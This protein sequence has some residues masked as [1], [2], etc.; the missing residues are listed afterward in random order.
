MK[1]KS[2]WFILLAVGWVCGGA[3]AQALPS[4]WLDVP[5][6]RYTD[7]YQGGSTC[8]DGVFT[9][10]GSGYDV[11]DVANDGGRFAFL[12]LLGDCEVIARVKKLQAELAYGA[13]AGLMLRQNNDRNAVNAVFGRM[14][15]DEVTNIGRI[16]S[17]YRS[18]VNAS[19]SSK[20]GNG[21]DYPWLLMRLIRQGNTVRSYIATNETGTVWELYNTQTVALGDAVNAGIFVSRNNVTTNAL[22]VMT[23]DF[24]QVAV[25]QLVTVQTNAA[26][27]FDVSWVTESPSL[28]NGWSYT[29]LLTRT[30]EGGSAVTQAQDLA[31][32]A[33]ADASVSAGTFYRYA[34]TAVPVPQDPLT[35]PP[36]VLIGTSA[37]T[38][39]PYAVTNLLAGLAQ[40]LYAAYYMPSTAVAPG[41]TRVENSV[42]NVVSLYPAGYTN[43]FKT[44]FNANLQAEAADLYT[45]FIESDDGV[46][47]WVGDT[48]IMDTWYG[49]LLKSSSGPVWL[50]AGRSYP[51]RVEY[52]QSTGARAC[53][54]QWRRAGAPEVSAA[55]PPS[56]LSPVPLPWRHEDIGDVSQN[57]NAAFDLGTGAI[58]VAANGN[59][60]TNSA[61][62][63][64]L[65]S[66]DIENDFDVAVRLD[67]LTGAGAD[68]RAGIV[69]RGDLTP[70]A[71]GVA[72][73]AVPGAGEYTVSVVARD[74]ADAAPSVAAYATG[75]A[76]GSALWLRLVRTGMRVA[77]YY[78][79]DGVTSWSPTRELTNAL[80]FATDKLGLVA[81]SAEAGGAAG[82]VFGAVA[83]TPAP[84]VALL[85]TDDVYLQADD[86]NYGTS[87]NL[88]MRRASG[89]QQREVFLR[90]NVAGLAAVSSAK[91]RLYVQA[92]AA[93]PAVQETVVRR[94]DNL[95]WSETA[96]R[97]S[98]APGGLRVPTVFL[99][100][101]DPTII[102]RANTPQ[103]GQFLEFDL[104]GVVRDAA[105][106]TG[107]LTLNLFTT[108]VYS[109]P[110]NFASKE[111]ADSAKRA[112]IVYALDKPAGL[113][114]DG[115]PETGNISLAWQAVTGATAYRV[116]RAAAAEGPYAQ[117]GGDLT[118]TV[119]KNTGLTGG[120]RYYYT[121]S[122]VL[123][124]GE[125]APSAP[126][127]AVAPATHT[128]VGDNAD[129]Y[130]QGPSTNAAN[131]GAASS[132]NTKY[133]VPIGTTS[134][135][136]YMR[137]DNV[138]GLGH[139]E[140]AVL[141][142][143][144]SQTG[145]DYAA[146]YV[147][148]R[149]MASNSWEEM[150]VSFSNPPPGIVLMTKA[151][152]V[153]NPLTTVRMQMPPAVGNML[154]MD[155]TPLVRRAAALN[156][157]GKMSIQIIRVDTA[158]GN[159][160][161]FYT[162]EDGTA[163]RRPQLVYTLGR[164]A[165]PAVAVSN[166]YASV[167]W[168][169]YRGAVGYVV[170]RAWAAEG[171]YTVV[172]NT[173]ALAFKDL[174]AGVGGIS[175]YT[176]TAVLAGGDAETSRPT[177][178]C[179]QALEARYPV[180]DTMIESNGGVTTT[181]IHGSDTAFNLKLSPV[182]ED[183]FKFD[184]GGL[185][186]A[187][188][189][190]FRVCSSAQNTS[191]TPVN[192][193]VR[194]GDFG[195]WNEYGVTYDAPPRGYTPPSVS[196]SAKGT[197]ELAR[198]NCPYKDPSDAFDNYLEADVTAAVRA[199]AQAGKRYITLFLTGDSTKQNAAGYM[200][201][202]SREYGTL[203]KR[204]V[205]L[206]SAS[207]FGAPQTLR[208]EPL[209][210]QAGFALTWRPVA[211]AV[212]YIVMR[213]GPQDGGSVVMLA[214]S[215]TGTSYT[216]AGPD[217]WN[218]RS[219]T[220]TVT[221][222]NADGTV[223]AAAQVA[224]A[225]P[226]TF[227]RPVVADTFV[228]GGA[229]TNSS[230]AL[231][232]LVEL[233]GDS[234]PD[235]EREGLFRVAVTGL[236]EVV[237]AQLRL[238]LNSTNTFTD[239]TVV[240]LATNDTGWAESGPTAPTWNTVMGPGAGRPPEPAPDDPAVIARFNLKAA[241][242]GRGDDMFFDITAQLKGAQARAEDTLMV[243]MFLTT[244]NAAGNFTVCSLQSADVGDVPYVLYTVARN[245]APG[246][247]LLLK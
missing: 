77:C 38:R 109:T 86:A 105:A 125:A 132:M 136:A 204:P 174:D 181:T 96:V 22:P 180:A 164:T 74:A 193:I 152:T 208:A 95:D 88:T 205:L 39:L 187:T 21:F 245:P 35:P 162:K 213:S 242:Y 179:V 1:R 61:D 170:R 238:K 49:A 66:R 189:V 128:A 138:A 120:Q 94:F 29:Y 190:R 92:R 201:V 16:T 47:M 51:V 215:V 37:A 195:D 186:S 101:D 113:T 111:Y 203:L 25:R 7:A 122:A 32:A 231:S 44:V 106:G 60:M 202:P 172:T 144:A 85:P 153:P 142:L 55:V 93:S 30:P 72:L 196:T 42:S 218:G 126:D 207:R 62:A 43:N 139:V 220:Y 116:Y 159:N 71:A 110:V 18:A 2:A 67:A 5:F 50:E 33:Y 98:S 34:V 75:V 178:V 129:T 59:A 169:A 176:L 102:G 52:Y 148:F 45:F 163:S 68:R 236:P 135:E 183:F 4:G 241:G 79:A 69:L 243:Q 89:T 246:T 99:A 145:P 54:L 11:Y 210:D 46:R 225:L 194:S 12:P 154:E 20:S 82:A 240:L 167:S 84:S 222:V 81:S 103:A 247:Q 146:T 119:L 157:D 200:S 26:A 65:V 232:P 100:D 73:L 107:D 192:F 221:A 36:N 53:T 17:A 177:A 233:K 230:Y 23:N 227:T 123:P 130:V 224:Q 165:A 124:G 149:L 10:A 166:G 6:G 117:V 78:R 70:G 90:F 211:G 115:G 185:E 191:Y 76:P 133:S 3:W 112:A 41:V 13:R 57:G 147:D 239:S 15:G 108:A 216:D 28:S 214:D 97:W 219:Y 184:V 104:T 199:A 160:S 229:S 212:R 197:N 83:I 171:P 40:G 206:C 118:A 63:C 244:L 223:S 161:A 137:F 158:T 168:P 237:R 134:R 64:H 121:V 31:T 150:A 24:D 91:L 228:R 226:L 56:A 151:D 140:K 48:Q 114:A 143:T 173:T 156:A 80:Y 127:S 234:N 87:T 235:Y 58:T 27:G 217:Y 19:T 182:R 155:V 175:F 209:A 131:Y 198:I 9:V 141:R 14:R 8:A 188:N